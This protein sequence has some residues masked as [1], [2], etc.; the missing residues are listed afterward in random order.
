MNIAMFTNTFTPH[1]GGVAR[2]VQGLTDELRRLGHRVLVVAP[3][4]SDLDEDEAGVLRM[5]AVQNFNGSDFSLPVPA[6]IKVSHAVK[7][8]RPDII[9]SHHPFL[10]G[11][12]ALRI[13]ATCN[14]PVVFTHHTRYE[15]YTHYLPGGDSEPLKHFVIDLVNGYC[16][17]CNTVVAPSLSIAEMLRT[18]EVQTPIEV[19]PTGIDPLYFTD[20]EAGP[21]RRRLGIPEECFVV[22]H[23]G[24]LAPEKNLRFLVRC[25]GEYLLRNPNARFLL[26]GEGPARE[27]M[28]DTLGSQGLM[29]RT[30]LLG[31]LDHQKLA[32]A[33]RCMDV[34]VFA[35][36][37]ETQGMVLAEAMAAETPVVALDAS[38]VREIVVDGVNGRLLP[39]EDIGRFVEALSWLAGMPREE[40]AR[41]R[42]SARRT[43]EEFSQ[44]NCVRK[45]LG[46]YGKL[47]GSET[48]LLEL[49][50][51]GWQ[52]ARNRIMKEIEILSKYGHAIEDTLR[53]L[54]LRK[55]S[56]DAEH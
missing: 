38:G 22:G 34:F 9:H 46:L 10:L 52:W 29:D 27:E 53:W 1:V 33:Y 12:T 48:S 16:N 25:V 56:S 40:R 6:P 32:D 41:L 20:S 8:F 35:S 2:S 13:A 36:Q 15:Q 14:V 37:S 17:L 44:E 45:M 5:P 49:D 18:Q 24:R 11:D 54:P 55:K 19:I 23:V 42:Q 7:D 30:H 4:F 3:R 43:A 28:L 47:A 51:S 39:V 50:D 21:I 31:I 26:V